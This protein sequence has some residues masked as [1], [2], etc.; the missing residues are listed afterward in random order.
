MNGRRLKIGISLLVLVCI[1]L[2]GFFIKEMMTE[3]AVA[4]EEIQKNLISVSG[5]GV[6]KVKPDIACINIGVET[7]NADAQ[8]AQQ[9]NARVMDKVV[10]KIRSLGIEEEDIKT[11]RYNLY[12]LQ[13]YD[14]ETGK[15]SVYEYRAVNIVEVT[16]RDI[17]KMGTVIDGVASV[18]SNTVSGIRFGVADNQKYYTDALEMAVKNA[19]GKAESIA[20][21]LGVTLKGAVNVQ[22]TSYGEPVIRYDS[23][24]KMKSDAEDVETPVSPGELEISAG[25]T[26]QFS[27]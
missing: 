27:Y 17:D 21:A 22:E 5:R 1:A 10:E 24:S 26:V 8:K 7:R 16:V 14:K 3:K 2:T 20:K 13:K 9:D 15:S 25:V 19:A 6:I 18:G 23:A 4:A 11:I 12:P